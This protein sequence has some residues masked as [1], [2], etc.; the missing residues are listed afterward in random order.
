MDIKFRN[1]KIQA[2]SIVLL[3]IMMP[4]TGCVSDETE[5]TSEADGTPVTDDRDGQEPSAHG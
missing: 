2:V 4:L 1:M 5:V 3:M